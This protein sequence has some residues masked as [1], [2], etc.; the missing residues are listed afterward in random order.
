MSVF[1]DILKYFFSGKTKE[2]KVL[3]SNNSWV[4]K[5]TI[6]IPTI[7]SPIDKIFFPIGTDEF[8][9]NKL[10]TKTFI[11]PVGKKSRKKAEE[12]LSELICKYKED[13]HIDENT[14]E[15]SI[16]RNPHIQYNKN[17]FIPSN[18]HYWFSSANNL[19]DLSEERK[20]E[21]TEEHNKEVLE[22]KRRRSI[23]NKRYY[24][25]RKANKLK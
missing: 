2:N 21:I 1:T 5:Y 12:S 13:V 19:N 23:V 11:I 24:Q 22:K 14:G 17:I 18:E 7:N 10:T 25:K 15:L 20:K 8:E 4:R 3:N 6:P 16:N 9:K